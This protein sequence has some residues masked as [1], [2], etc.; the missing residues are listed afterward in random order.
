MC[1]ILWYISQSWCLQ[2]F[3][4]KVSSV[5]NRKKRRKCIRED[6]KTLSDSQGTLG[7]K[8]THLGL[9]NTSTVLVLEFWVSHSWIL[10]R[11]ILACPSTCQKLTGKR[12]KNTLSFVLSIARK[13]LSFQCLLKLQFPQKHFS[14]KNYRKSDRDVICF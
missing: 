2:T 12:E 10:V 3:I 9:W 4:L 1:K 14:H 8:Y 7:K 6:K 11:N 5:S 13:R